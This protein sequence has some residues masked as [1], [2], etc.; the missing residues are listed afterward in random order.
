MVYVYLALKLIH[1][2]AAITAV[3]SNITY[4]V[5]NVRAQSNPAQLGFA[6]KGIKFIDDHIAN[7]AYGVLLVTGLLMVFVN[8]WPVGSLWIILALILFAAL[9][10]LAFRVYSPLLRNQIRLVDAG[11]TT[12]RRPDPRTPR[13][14]DPDPD[15][16]QAHPVAP[17]QRDHRGID[18]A[19][20]AGDGGWRVARRNVRPRRDRNPGPA[21]QGRAEDLQ[22]A[23]DEEDR[24]EKRPPRRPQEEEGENRQTER[25]LDVEPPGH[26]RQHGQTEQRPGPGA[27]E[28][29]VRHAAAVP[30]HHRRL[31]REEPEQVNNA[32]PR[33]H[34]E[35]KVMQP[36]AV[37]AP[38]DGAENL[39]PCGHRDA[40]PHL[41]ALLFGSLEGREI[42][43]RERKHPQHVL[44]PLSCDPTVGEQPERG[45]D[46][47]I[48]V[49]PIWLHA[50]RNRRD[51]LRVPL[52]SMMLPWSVQPVPF[53]VITC[54]CMIAKWSDEAVLTLMPGSR[55]GFVSFS[56]LA[57]ISMTF[58]RVML[59]PACFSTSTMV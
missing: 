56:R 13:R 41:H 15:G 14:G 38:D 32:V 39:E 19:V 23:D 12:S 31:R 37:D 52:S 20:G 44:L 59:V 21:A 16:V 48:R 34:E 2:G 29:R 4:G 36:V 46:Q 45:V 6:L 24:G 30:L 17:K 57:A 3:G 50:S 35:R 1:I 27:A 8:R 47:E 9:A 40:Q 58:F 43:D 5:W 55:N 10:V 18:D 26:Q 22:L 11:D 53:Q 28:H 7:P 33:R 51:Y 49:Q 54:S 42:K 25:A